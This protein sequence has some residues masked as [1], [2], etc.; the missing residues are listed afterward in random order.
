MVLL[1]K[2]EASIKLNVIALIVEVAFHI[3]AI[4]NVVL[5]N[6]WNN[7]PASNGKPHTIKPEFDRAFLEL[8][9]VYPW[10]AHVSAIWFASQHSLYRATVNEPLWLWMEFWSTLFWNPNFYIN[11]VE[12]VLT[13]HGRYNTNI[14]SLL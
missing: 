7:D 6:F 4:P 2:N 12:P 9:N 8:F 11:G 13:L 3:K 14:Q 1:K 10:V 5:G